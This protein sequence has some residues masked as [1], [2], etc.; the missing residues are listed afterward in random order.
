MEKEPTSLQGEG[1][2]IP[3]KKRGRS[4]RRRKTD[5]KVTAF[6]S[7]EPAKKRSRGKQ[8]EE[9]EEEEFVPPPEEVEEDDYEEDDVE[10]DGN[11]DPMEVEDEDVEVVDDPDPLMVT[12][13]QRKSLAEINMV[14]FDAS[15]RLYEKLC[16]SVGN[17]TLKSKI[18]ADALNS[19]ALIRSLAVSTTPSEEPVTLPLLPP[20]GPRITI[21]Q[22]IKALGLPIDKADR[23]E[24]GRLARGFYR[25]KNRNSEPYEEATHFYNSE[26]DGLVRGTRTVYTENDQDIVDKAILKFFAD[27]DN[28]E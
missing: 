18:M 15:L 1:T 11:Y 6:P 19:Y 5:G 27:L 13:E 23:K 10:K 3:P 28:S 24:I 14:A 8:D 2:N 22:R 25:R 9:N 21:T 4:K 17:E 12:L 26:A 20:A 7:P 16:L